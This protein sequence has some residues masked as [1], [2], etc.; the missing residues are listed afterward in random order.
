MTE[1]R[2]KGPGNILVAMLD[3]E[4]VAEVCV[5]FGRIGASAET[6]AEECAAEVRAYIS[7]AHPVGTHLADQ[8]LLPMALGAGGDFITCQPS[9]HT[10]TN[11]AVIRAF[12]SDRNALTELSEANWLTQ[13][14]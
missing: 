14:R 10:R 13:I 11:M 4:H 8:L 3:Y 7:G 6:I 2:A 5:A 1:R 12:L 9:S